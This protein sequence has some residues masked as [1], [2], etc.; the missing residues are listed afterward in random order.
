MD[1]SASDHRS[2]EDAFALLGSDLRLRIVRALSEVDEPLTFSALRERVEERDS[3]R[4]NYHLGKLDGW[5]VTRTDA[6]YRLTYAGRQ[7]VGAVIA[8]TYNSAV[9]ID[10]IPLEDPCPECGDGRLEIDIESE[11]VVVVCRSC[12]DWRLQFPFPP[13]TVSQF[14]RD[15]L[16]GALSR[17][18]QLTVERLFAGFCENCGGRIEGRYEDIADDD[19][20]VVL[21]YECPHCHYGASVTADQ[22]VIAHRVGGTF[23][24][25]HGHAP[26]ETPVWQL[27]T[28]V[29]ERSVEVTETDDGR[30]VTVRLR[31]DDEVLTATLG[32]DLTLGSIG[33][34]PKQ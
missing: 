22:P 11:L 25:D 10:V 31:V 16:P 32:P 9:T 27:Q 20:P 18:L 19:D 30:E 8:G 15:A 4:F 21:V 26:E 28:A 1:D 33:R 29:D 2:P 24:A 17:W 13:G 23:F 34:R 14:D 3:G 5:F 6:G 7:V 12:E